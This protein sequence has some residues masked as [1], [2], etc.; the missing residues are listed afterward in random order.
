MIM[1]GQ[2]CYNS[3]STAATVEHFINS[4]I[5]R[6]SMRMR[7]YTRA[8]IISCPHPKNSRFKDHSGLKYG[9]CTV[10]CYAGKKKKNSNGS[11]FVECDCGAISKRRTN[12][13]IKSTCCSSCQTARKHGDTETPTYKSW[14]SMIQ[15]C[16]NPKNPA[17]ESYGGRGIGVAERWRKYENFL[18]DMGKRTAKQS[19]ERIDNNKGYSPDNCE[20]AEKKQQNN[21]TRKNRTIEMGGESLTVALWCEKLGISQGRVY[22]RLHRKWCGLCALTLPLGE[23]CPHKGD[24]Q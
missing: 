8:E 9:T 16:T 14:A 13:I 4:L 18:E 11:W 17:Y 19:I 22:M 7:Y 5:R 15:R 21:N 3:H 12:E 6:L 23:S 24:A 1:S 20:W 10:L 2:I